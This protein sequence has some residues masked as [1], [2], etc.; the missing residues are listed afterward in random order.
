MEKVYVKLHFKFHDF[1]P[2]N[3]EDMKILILGFFLSKHKPI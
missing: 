3:N 1:S 2:W